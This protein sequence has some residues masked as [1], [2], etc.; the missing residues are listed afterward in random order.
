MGAAGSINFLYVFSGLGVG[1]LVGMTG[2][3]G[4]S[5]MTPLL[6]LLFGVHPATAVGTDL[7]YASMTKTIGTVVHGFS[8]NIE[9]RVVGR[10]ASGSVPATILMVYALSR[11]DLMSAQAAHDI[12]FVLGLALLLTSLTLIFRTRFVSWYGRTVGEL[13]PRA[14]TVTTIAVG[15]LLGALVSATSVGAGALGVTAL[16][17]LYPRLPVG[18]IVGSDI[19]HAVPLTLI[20]GLGH[21]FIG[22]INFGVLSSLLIGSMPGIVLGS[23]LA[24]RVPDVLLRFSLAA[25]LVVVGG[26]LVM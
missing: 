23:Y 3:G 4:G 19:V 17:V 12:S 20:A 6:I 1:I 13:S 10:L 9:W 21:W 15:A 22:S 14:T 8:N 25:V 24:L 2:V 7:L 16:I 5:L 18:R 11:V 26:T